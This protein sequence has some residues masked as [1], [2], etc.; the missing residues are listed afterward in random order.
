M[1]TT[2]RRGPSRRRV[3]LSCA[4]VLGLEPAAAS[5]GGLDLDLV[6]ARAIGRAGTSTVSGD[7]AS[8]LIAEPAGLARSTGLRVQVGLALHDDDMRFA[9]ADA[10]QTGSPTILDRSSP[11]LVPSVAVQ[12]AVGPVVLGVAYLELGHLDRLLPAPVPGQPVGPLFPHRYGGLSLRYRRRAVVAGAA[13]RAGDWLGLGASIGASDVQL[14]ERRRVWAGFA[15][16]DTIADDR[17]DLDL[18]LGGRDRLVPFAAVG[19]LIAPTVVPI[20]LAASLS[21]SADAELDGELGLASTGIGR[22]FPDPREVSNLEADTRVAMPTVLR[23]GVRYL[24]ERFV[25]EANADLTWF[26]DEGAV[27]VWSTSG[28]MVADESGFTADLGD[29][30][31]LAAQRDHASARGAVD[32]EI[33]SGLLWA[34]AG[35]AY[36]TGA[37]GR[38]HISPGFGDL[39][40]HTAAI[41]AEAAWNGM[42]FTIGLARRFSPT[43]SV[44]ADESAVEI[45]NPFNGG[46]ASAGAGRHGRAHDAVGLTVEVAWE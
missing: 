7:G 3:A 10:A 12:G 37:T 30:P 43:V 31:S 22:R 23:A 18:D 9:A 11:E 2:P 24:G 16:R 32:V 19:A 34:T 27:P 29:I 14:D 20:E 46:T 36:A 45:E 8:A 13:V 44:T 40:G 21:W 41:G 26:G 1:T 39:A 38:A 5:A 42:T 15:G 4:L 28:M 35:Y 25:V 17:R 6:G 33:V